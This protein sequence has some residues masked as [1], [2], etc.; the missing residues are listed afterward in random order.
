MLE[1]R[2]SGRAPAVVTHHAATVDEALRGAL[3]K[4]KRRFEGG[5]ASSAGLPRARFQSR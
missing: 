5:P 1:A 3:H 4:L 2:P